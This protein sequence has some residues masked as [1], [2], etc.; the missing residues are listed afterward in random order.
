MHDVSIAD[1]LRYVGGV[2]AGRIVFQL[3]SDRV[4]KQQ[5]TF[6]FYG[7]KSKDGIPLKYA[8]SGFPHNGTV[9]YGS[10]FPDEAFSVKHSKLFLL[11]MVNSG[12]NTNRSQFCIIVAPTSHLDGK[13]VVAGEVRRGKGFATS[14]SPTSGRVR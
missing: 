14:I 8:G 10:K 9:I 6:V 1:L 7:N 12:L 5:R 13:H 11:S 3:D 2:P 4:P